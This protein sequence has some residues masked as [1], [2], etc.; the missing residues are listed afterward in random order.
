MKL[1]TVP[2]PDDKQMADTKNEKEKFGSDAASHAADCSCVLR[3]KKTAL[4]RPH[5]SSSVA[6]AKGSFAH[7][8]TNI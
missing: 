6:R 5:E 8:R 7:I 2:T 3:S 1:D 4:V